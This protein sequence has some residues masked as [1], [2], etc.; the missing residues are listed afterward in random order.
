[1]EYGAYALFWVL[2]VISHLRTMCSDPGFIPYNY[3]YKEEILVAP[4]KTLAAIESA[5]LKNR[6]ETVDEPIQAAVSNEESCG[7][8]SCIQN[9]SMAA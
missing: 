8:F 3:T 6:S 9:E 7:K 2:M 5:Y 4:F 1:M